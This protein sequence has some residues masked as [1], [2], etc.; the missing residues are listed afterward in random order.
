LVINNISINIII[1]FLL[2]KKGK[3]IKIAKKNFRKQAKAKEKLFYIK[4]Q[5]NNTL[6]N[7][8]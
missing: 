8:K 5:R 4:G 6:R 7:Y 1:N 2:K 3:E